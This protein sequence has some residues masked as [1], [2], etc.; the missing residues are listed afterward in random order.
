MAWRNESG[1]DC[2]AL[3]VCCRDLVGDITVV[4]GLP[5]AVTDE[6]VVAVDGALT[7]IDE[8]R[9]RAYDLLTCYA[10]CVFRIE[11]GW[12]FAEELSIAAAASGLPDDI[13]L[14]NY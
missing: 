3:T 8:L 13:T 2:L 4:H 6:T 14:F 9:I 7:N 10:T 12:L 1:Q 5:M 11:E